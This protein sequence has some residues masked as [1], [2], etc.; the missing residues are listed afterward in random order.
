MP[1]TKTS[2]IARPG[3]LL[4]HDGKWHHFSRADRRGT[5]VSDC[6]QQHIPST[7]DSSLVAGSPDVIPFPQCDHCG[8]VYEREHPTRDDDQDRVRPSAEE[9]RRLIDRAD[10]MTISELRET[11][12]KYGHEWLTGIRKPKLVQHFRRVM[13]K[14]ADEITLVARER[15]WHVVPTWRSGVNQPQKTA[16]GETVVP[17]AVRTAPRTDV[18]WRAVCPGCGKASR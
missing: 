18:S 12:R 16:C 5:R 17:D 15:V 7:L 8:D 2:P 4:C 9:A 11:G 1:Q 13:Q 10:T 14:Y 3:W 6:A